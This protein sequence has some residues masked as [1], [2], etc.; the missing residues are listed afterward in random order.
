MKTKGISRNG[1]KLLLPCYQ[2]SKHALVKKRANA[3]NANALR[4]NAVAFDTATAKEVV[5]ASDLCCFCYFEKKVTLF[6][7]IH[8]CVFIFK[9]LLKLNSYVERFMKQKI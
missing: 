6:Y 3:V 8:C 5:K 9:D 7:E 2:L 1:V 4:V